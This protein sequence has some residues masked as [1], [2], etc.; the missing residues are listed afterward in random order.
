[1]TSSLSQADVVRLMKDRSP[2][3]RAETAARVA[4][5]FDINKKTLSNAERQLALDIFR[6]MVR[7]AEIQVRQALSDNLK[8]CPEVPHDIALELARDV[9]EVALPM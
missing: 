7:D 5:N 4:H 2:V 9:D 8:K 6:L 1:M 3:V